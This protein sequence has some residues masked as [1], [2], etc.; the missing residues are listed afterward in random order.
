MRYVLLHNYITQIYICIIKNYITYILYH[1]LYK[2]IVPV[3]I[4][5]LMEGTFRSVVRS[6]TLPRT[7][8]PKARPCTTDCVARCRLKPFAYQ[9]SRLC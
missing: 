5:T 8:P 4:G 1:T 7:L 2:I 3:H 9:P 6:Y